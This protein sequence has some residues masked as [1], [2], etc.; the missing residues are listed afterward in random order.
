MFE[1]RRKLSGEQGANDILRAKDYTSKAFLD[2]LI[3]FEQKDVIASPEVQ[4]YLSELWV[5]KY[6]VNK[7]NYL[8]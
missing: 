6:I 1:N 5:G 3:Q 7:K 4:E 2:S 8:I